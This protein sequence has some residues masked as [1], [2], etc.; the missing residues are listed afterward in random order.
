[1]NPGSAQRPPEW[2]SILTSGK[3]VQTG[4]LQKKSQLNLVVQSIT[5]RNL[6]SEYLQASKLKFQRLNGQTYHSNLSSGKN[7]NDTSPTSPPTDIS[8]NS[9]TSRV[10]HKQHD[11][12]ISKPGTQ[13]V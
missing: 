4:C 9:N 6:G 12:A 3:T 8:R 13:E 11:N 10:K 5:S 1:M 7:K 2:F